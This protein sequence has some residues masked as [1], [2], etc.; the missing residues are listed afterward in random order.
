MTV[1]SLRLRGPGN[2]TWDVLICA[3]IAASAA[4]LLLGFG[5]VPADA[6]V[7]LSRTYLVEHGALVWDNLWYSGDFPLAAYSLLYY[8]SLIHI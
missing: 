1:Y 8:L 6:E 7:H 2:R 5:P 3:S 4:G